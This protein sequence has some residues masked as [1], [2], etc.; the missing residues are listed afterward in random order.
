MDFSESHLTTIQTKKEH[1]TSI[2]EAS[3]HSHLNH[4][5]P[6]PLL[7][8]NQH[9][10]S[11]KQ[12]WFLPLVNFRKQNCAV[13]PDIS[14]VIHHYVCDIHPHYCMQLVM[15]G[16]SVTGVQQTFSLQSQIVSSFR[17]DCHKDS[18]KITQLCR[19]NTALDNPETDL[20]LFQLNFIYR[21][22]VIVY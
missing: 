17:F 10:D 20:A 22:K 19:I 11:C 16:S 5:P 21:S 13:S 7:E 18:V 6:F 1:I 14:G 2:P 9:P 8:G 12:G 15:F 3:S 4:Y